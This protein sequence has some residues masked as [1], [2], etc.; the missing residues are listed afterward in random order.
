MAIPD[1]QSLFLPVLR[2][3][4]DGRDHSV[5]ETIEYVRKEF[6]LTEKDMSATLKGGAKTVVYD[7]V[8]WAI[9]YLRHALLLEN[10]K[11]GV[12]HITERGRALLAD[13]PTSLN[14]KELTRFDEFAAWLSSTKAGKRS[15]TSE[16][17]Q[18]DDTQTPE[19]LIEENFTVLERQLADEL[20]NQ[21]KLNS[22]GFFERLVVELLVKMGYGGSFE[23]AGRAIG[24]SGDEGIDGVINEDRLGLDVIYIQAK[25]WERSVGRP[26]IQSFVGALAG[27]KARKGVFITTSD[28]SESARKYAKSLENKVVLIDG[29]QLAHFMIEHDI[30]VST[31]STYKIKKIDSD[32][33]EID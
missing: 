2:S 18:V 8:T 7:R 11:R 26:E 24:R 12:F 32:Y 30:G 21:V 1:F 9:S 23:D 19:E 13:N 20:L 6:H 31:V 5:R 29:S 14:I 15:T 28:F 17:S 22:P 16:A 10:V 4:E 27:Q 33:F 25:R 3:L